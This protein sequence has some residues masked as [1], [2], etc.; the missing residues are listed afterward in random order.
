MH[1]DRGNLLSSSVDELLDAASQSQEALLVQEALVPSVEPSACEGTQA[2][3]H[4]WHTTRRRNTSENTSTSLH[5]ML[6]I[7]DCGM[8]PHEGA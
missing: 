2:A 1:L 4:A 5:R 8:R 6:S 3:F 7:A